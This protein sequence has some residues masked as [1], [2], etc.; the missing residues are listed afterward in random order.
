[1]MRF[2]SAAER[3]SIAAIVALSVVVMVTVGL[4][5]WRD[6]M[7][8]RLVVHSRREREAVKSS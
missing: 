2:F 8:C 7:S 1:M 4:R 6:V 3:L 5:L